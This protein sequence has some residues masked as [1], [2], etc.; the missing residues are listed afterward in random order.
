MTPKDMLYET[1]RMNGWDDPVW[2]G[3]T[4]VMV[5]QKTYSLADLESH[6]V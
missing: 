1:A 6:K 4:A 5:N 3:N 2:N